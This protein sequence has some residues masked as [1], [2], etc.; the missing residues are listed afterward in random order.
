MCAI[1]DLQSIISYCTH[2][3]AHCCLLLLFM[4]LKFISFISE[5]I[6]RI[7]AAT[8]YI[9]SNVYLPPMLAN[10]ADDLTTKHSF[11]LYRLLCTRSTRAQTNGRLCARGMAVILELVRT[12]CILMLQYSTRSIECCNTDLHAI[13]GF[14]HLVAYP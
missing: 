7:V 5:V 14:L 2:L 8:Q 11:Q 4:C 1:G 3:T 10:Q 12:K 13:A 6:D 9:R